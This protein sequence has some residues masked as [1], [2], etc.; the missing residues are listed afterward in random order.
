[1]IVLWGALIGA[2]AMLVFDA[3]RCWWRARRDAV[4]DRSFVDVQEALRGFCD[5]VDLPSFRVVVPLYDW[6]AEGA[7]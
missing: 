5:D 6:K 7:A 3:V 4:V 2:V 1:M